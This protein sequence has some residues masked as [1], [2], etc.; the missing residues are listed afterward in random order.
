[1][2]T[3]SSSI[4]GMTEC[5][6]IVCIAFANSI[7]PGCI[8][9]PTERPRGYLAPSK[10]GVIVIRT[11]PL[12]VSLN[13]GHKW[14]FPMRR[15]VL[16]TPHPHLMAV[17]CVLA[18]GGGGGGVVFFF[19]MFWG[20]VS[21]YIINIPAKHARTHTEIGAVCTTSR[22]GALTRTALYCSQHPCDEP[23]SISSF[24]PIT[25]VK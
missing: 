15:A 21:I 25:R 18:G 4:L 8:V 24:V 20:R 13:Q 14:L 2:Q 11:T 17:L 9:P 6:S 10:H 1:M 16:V 5:E 23:C 22:Y 19:F 7:N 3:V 12:N